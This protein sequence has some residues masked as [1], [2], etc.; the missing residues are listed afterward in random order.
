[1]HQLLAGKCAVKSPIIASPSS[2]PLAI[3]R[4]QP[5]TPDTDAS[6]HAPRTTAHR[7]GGPDRMNRQRIPLL[8]LWENCAAIPR[9]ILRALFSM[10][11]FEFLLGFERP[12]HR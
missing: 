12:D 11:S 3:P 5:C 9:T 6:G 4:P 7:R 10:E 2:V 8:T 1:M